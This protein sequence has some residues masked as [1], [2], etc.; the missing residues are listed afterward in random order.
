MEKLG[1]AVSHGDGRTVVYAANPEFREADL[2][3]GLLAAGASQK[4][5]SVMGED[6]SQLVLANLK[7]MG[8]PLSGHD[9]EAR[10]SLTPEETLARA[11]L[12]S[13]ESP[14]V[15]R[16]LPWLLTRWAGRLDMPALKRRAAELRQTRTLGFVLDVAG[17]LSHRDRL[18]KEANTL[19]D[20]RVKCSEFFFTHPMGKFTEALARRNTPPLARKWHFELNMPMESFSSFFAKHEMAT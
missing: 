15:L 9:E 4:P 8:A 20:A 5:E 3:R 12:L 6:E 10:E 14:T 17:V 2:L 19:H 1:L 16:V 13:R 7:A 18:R 11:M